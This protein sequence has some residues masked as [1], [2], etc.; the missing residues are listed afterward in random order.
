MNLSLRRLIPLMVIAV[1]L[2]AFSLGGG[3]VTSCEGGCFGAACD[4]AAAH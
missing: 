3:N 4:V 1:L 2:C